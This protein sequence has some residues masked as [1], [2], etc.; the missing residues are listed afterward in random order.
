MTLVCSHKCITRPHL[1]C[2]STW[3]YTS[4]YGVWLLED[5]I[6]E[7]SVADEEVLEG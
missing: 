1:L 6:E 5:L 2:E 7:H 4:K 3:G